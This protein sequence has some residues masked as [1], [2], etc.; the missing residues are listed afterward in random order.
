[1]L[2]GQ[3]PPDVPPILMTDMT[4]VPNEFVQK[5]VWYFYRFDD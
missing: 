1:M 3:K 4:L 2:T 5:T